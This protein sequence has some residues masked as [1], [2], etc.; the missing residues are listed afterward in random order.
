[1]QVIVPASEKTEIKEM[2]LNYAYFYLI[3]HESLI[4]TFYDDDIA[5]GRHYITC[6]SNC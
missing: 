4:Y 2:L 1:M 3:W 6:L 5:S